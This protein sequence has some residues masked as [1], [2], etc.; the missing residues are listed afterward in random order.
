MKKT[1]KELEEERKQAAAQQK[2]AKK[3]GVWGLLLNGE[4]NGDEEGGIDFALGNVFRFMLFTQKKETAERA[5]L[6]RIADSLDTLTSR[7][8][9]IER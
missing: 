5:Q 2:K 1:K 6:L 8:D 3:E 7:L 9:H 4:G